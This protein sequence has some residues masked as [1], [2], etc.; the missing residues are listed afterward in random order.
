MLQLPDVSRPFKY[1]KMP[2]RLDPGAF[3]LVV[4]R[5]CQVRVAFDLRQRCRTVHVLARSQAVL[6]PL[7]TGR[8]S[9]LLLARR[10]SSSCLPSG[11][12]Y[13]QAVNRVRSELH[14]LWRAARQYLLASFP[15]IYSPQSSSRS[16]HSLL[17]SGCQYDQA[18]AALSLHAYEV[19]RM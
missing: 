2:V 3:L 4:S 13:F 18:S 19:R 12:R 6:L 16:N 11:Y 15:I 9:L 14:P 8:I 17:F 7:K 5:T 10:P 1:S